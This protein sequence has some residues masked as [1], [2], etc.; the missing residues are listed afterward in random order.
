MTQNR[1]TM[2]K[3]KKDAFEVTKKEKGMIDDDEKRRGPGR[4][5]EPEKRERLIAIA[6]QIFAE[7]GFAA[8][9]LG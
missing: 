6:R 4:P 9:S 7:S 1:L 5:K 8:T 2:Q 3:M